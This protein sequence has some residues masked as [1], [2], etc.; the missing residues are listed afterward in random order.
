MLCCGWLKVMK[1]DPLKLLS[2]LEPTYNEEICEEVARVIVNVT[3]NKHILN[4]LSKPEIQAFKEEVLN[5][6]HFDKMWKFS[7]EQA[8]SNL[9]TV[10][11][12]ID[13]TNILFLRIRCQS[14]QKMEEKKTTETQ[15]SKILPDMPD[16]CNALNLHLNKL[17]NAVPE[18][19]DNL[20]SENSSVQD[21][22]SYIC[23]QILQLVELCDL[24]EEGSRRHL[25][26][27][28]QSVMVM[29][30]TPDDVLQKCVLILLAT[31]STEAQF[32]QTISEVLADINDLKSNH[33]DRSN[34]ENEKHLKS[35][36]NALNLAKMIRTIAIISIVLENI[37]SRMSTNTILK[38]LASTY[39]E[40]AIT[41]SDAMVREAGVSCLGKF[42]IMMMQDSAILNET[43]SILLNVGSNVKERMETR[44]Q[45][46]LALTDLSMMHDSV[47][48][49]ITLK[50]SS[51]ENEE[52]N[53]EDEKT[54]YSRGRKRRNRRKECPLETEL[55]VEKPICLVSILQDMLRQSRHPALC[56]IAAECSAKLMFAGKVH[57][58]ISLAYLIVMYFNDDFNSDDDEVGDCATDIGSPVR[59][60]QLLTLFFPAYC[61]RFKLGRVAMMSSI[62]H[63]LELIHT[64]MSKRVRGRRAFAWPIV[65]MIEYVCNNVEEGE[66]Q[67]ANRDRNSQENPTDD[68]VEKEIMEEEDQVD[69]LEPSPILLLA[70]AISEFL[71][72]NGSDLPVRFLRILCKVLNGIDLD[73]E[74]ESI[75]HLNLLT[76]KMDELSLVITDSSSLRSLESMFE[77]LSEIPNLE[78]DMNGDEM[79]R[80]SID[81]A[82]T[83]LSG[84]TK[85]SCASVVSA[86]Q[87]TTLDGETIHG[88]KKDDYVHDSTTKQR[89]DSMEDDF[90]EG[91]QD[92]SL[93][94]SEENKENPFYHV[95]SKTFTPMKKKSKSIPN[96]EKD[97]SSPS[98]L[99]KR[100]NCTPV[101]SA[102][103]PRA[104]KKGLYNHNQVI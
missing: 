102:T 2:R 54:E 22:E 17:N 27:L 38:T 19:S 36:E 13:V 60:Q 11:T 51:A 58:S 20:D 78:S 34:V 24:K 48:S 101:K 46:V 3:E 83:E 93:L 84:S 71:V 32:I 40:P 62:K 85:S 91:T 92:S 55:E 97:T 94:Q 18:E 80:D 28:L 14:L 57:D 74:S 82:K 96:L 89:I 56:V 104:T 63:M 50:V 41:H 99:N 53:N 79:K 31:H 76:T 103:K 29:L 25:A 8:Q 98:A 21:I 69:D 12:G 16:I 59:L 52:N 44:A 37:S 35:Q 26:S 39:I 90:F 1:F 4:E 47:L 88:S 10:D 100:K 45:A 9:N 75:Q 67:F 42:T 15:L 65:K 66:E 61:M 72:E 43:K 73:L 5:V 86:F 33:D 64:K 6:K 23:L 95:L 77:V 68:N 70:I 30:N 7:S 81:S 87:S 49:P